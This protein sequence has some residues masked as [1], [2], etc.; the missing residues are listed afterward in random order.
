MN[1]TIDNKSYIPYAVRIKDRTI[2]KCIADN[3]ETIILNNIW[4]VNNNEL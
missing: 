3:N 1:I 2:L 4:R